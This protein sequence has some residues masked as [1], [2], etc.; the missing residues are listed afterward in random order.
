MW[1]RL[2][3]VRAIASPTRAVALAVAGA[4]VLAVAA[5]TPPT[6]ARS[7]MHQTRTSA[8]APPA[9][10]RSAAGAAPY[11]GPLHTCTAA[12]LRAR[13]RGGGF[14]TGSD[15]AS[16]WIWDVTS[17]R[18]RLRG[19]LRFAARDRDG[20]LDPN[21]AVAAWHK[22]RSVAVVLRADAHRPGLRTGPEGYLML[23]LDGYERDDPARPNGLCRPQDEVRPRVLLVAVGKDRWRL[24]NRDPDAF[25]N[26]RG[27]YGCHGK[28]TLSSI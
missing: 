12:S 14:G 10:G 25:Q 15:F 1:C 13:F 6:S 2:T 3:H 19:R 8:A 9:S 18:C 20:Q 21:A 28:I 16:V 17:S 5:C 26:R 23:I 22:R 4:V 24:P 11:G 27:V 7:P